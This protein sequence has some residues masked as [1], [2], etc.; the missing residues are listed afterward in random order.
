MCLGSC[1]CGAIKSTRGPI[2]PTGATGATGP[3]GP[4]GDPGEAPQTY[5]ADKEYNEPANDIY[6]GGSGYAYLVSNNL[7][8]GTNVVWS[9]TF[10]VEATDVHNVELY[11]SIN[12]SPDPTYKVKHTC[13]AS[14]GYSGQCITYNG[15][16]AY[17]AG[18]TFH[19]VLKSDGAAVTPVLKTVFGHFY[20]I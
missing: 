18:N 5:Y 14:A 10:Q 3:A 11:P 17:T 6:N 16:S 19:I 12:G 20:V 4:Q 2:G 9:I 13:Y 8:A 7:P 15:H 1:G